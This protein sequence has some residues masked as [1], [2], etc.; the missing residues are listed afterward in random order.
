MEEFCCKCNPSIAYF[1]TFLLP[2]QPRN[3][4]VEVGRALPQLVENRKCGSAL[5]SSSRL[6]PTSVGS[7]EFMSAQP[8]FS[9]SLKQ[10]RHQEGVKC[11]SPLSPPLA[12]GRLMEE[13]A[14]LQ[15]GRGISCSAR[16]PAPLSTSVNHLAS[17]PSSSPSVRLKECRPTLNVDC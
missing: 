12:V 7:R 2:Q 9:R 6:K 1:I 15:W 8:F 10:G 13:S 11:A 4:S 17:G 16:T 3:N 5:G 14:V